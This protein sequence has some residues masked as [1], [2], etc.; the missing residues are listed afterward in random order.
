MVQAVFLIRLNWVNPKTG[1]TY[2]FVVG[3]PGYT[4]DAFYPYLGTTSLIIP[5]PQVSS[6]S[7]DRLSWWETI[8]NFLAFFVGLATFIFVSMTLAFY[9]YL[10]NLLAKIVS[11]LS[12][13]FSQGIYFHNCVQLMTLFFLLFFFHRVPLKKHYCFKSLKT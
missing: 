3:I 12:L 5:T 10:S 6:S 1:M 2:S 13:F 4:M 8:F 7:V 9:S 11:N